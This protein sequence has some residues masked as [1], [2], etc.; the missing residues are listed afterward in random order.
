MGHAAAD[1]ATQRPGAGVQKRVIANAYDGAVMFALKKPARGAQS[2][3]AKGRGGVV[4]E[5]TVERC[6]G[7]TARGRTEG[8]V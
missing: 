2:F 5:L 8:L 1:A 6:V 3:E 7:F 4:L